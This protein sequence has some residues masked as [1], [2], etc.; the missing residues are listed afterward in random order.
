MKNTAGP[1]DV[2][3]NPAAGGLQGKK[4]PIS[5]QIGSHDREV[6][7]GTA[8]IRYDLPDPAE[9]SA[10]FLSGCGG[11]ND[12]QTPV[13]L[14]FFFFFKSCFRIPEKIL[15]QMGKDRA[16]LESGQSVCKIDIFSSG[17]PLFRSDADDILH[18]FAGK[19]KEVFFCAL[20][21]AVRSDSNI[22]PGISGNSK[23]KNNLFGAADQFS[24][25][26]VLYSSKSCKAVEYDHR[27]PKA[28]GFGNRCRQQIHCLL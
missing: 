22:R 2:D 28:H 8:C 26:P 16:V 23:R 14:P 15:F 13:C 18:G 17:Q 19:V 12:L 21:A 11:G 6:A 1:V 3:G 27:P 9:D 25:H 24:D 20:A 10:H 4:I 7:V 5:L